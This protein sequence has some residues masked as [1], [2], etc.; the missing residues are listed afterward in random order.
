MDRLE[1]GELYCQG[2]AL[3]DAAA[4]LAR[5][6]ASLRKTRWTATRTDDARA[7]S[8]ETGCSDPSAPPFVR[9]AA[10]SAHLSTRRAGWETAAWRVLA[11]DAAAV[12]GF[13][14]AEAAAV[15]TESRVVETAA[16]RLRLRLQLQLQ[17]QRDGGITAAEVERWW[18]A[19]DQLAARA[20]ATSELLAHNVEAIEYL[21]CRWTEAFHRGG[22]GVLDDVARD[23]ESSDSSDGGGYRPS[24][25]SVTPSTS[26]SSIEEPVATRATPLRTPLGRAMSTLDSLTAL[27]VQFEAVVLSLSAAF[28]ALRALRFGHDGDEACTTEWEPPSSFERKTTKYWVEPKDVVRLKLAIVRHLPVLVFEGAG[29]KAKKAVTVNG[30]QPGRDSGMITSVYLDNAHLDVYHSRL[31]REQGATLVRTRWYGDD[32]DVRGVHGLEARREA[33]DNSIQGDVFVERKTHH[34]S[35]SL[36]GSV[37]E[38][39]RLDRCE[40]AGYLSGRLDIPSILRG[41]GA[42]EAE[43]AATLA[44]EVVMLELRN[45][46]LEPSV[47]TEYRRTAFQLSSSNTVRMSLDTRLRFTRE[48]GSTRAATHAFP[49]AILE[50]KLQEAS[51]DW[52]E[53]V[54]ARVPVIE[55]HKFSKFLHGTV[56]TG[57]ETS[58][59]CRTV[60]RVPHWCTE[61]IFAGLKRAERRQEALKCARGLGKTSCA[62]GLHGAEACPPMEAS[63]QCNAVERVA[64]SS[65]PAPISAPVACASSKEAGM[66]LK[67]E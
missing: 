31:E 30:E 26:T 61:E 47:R 36:D 42:A 23:V 59:T 64:S 1:D 4:A 15:L 63:Q 54:M 25:S 13:V 11:E 9:H 6:F 40:L 34:E 50:V 67:I 12:A 39:F 52:I 27:D 65:H 38:R 33:D 57:A 53:E 29:G 32:P 62:V 8:S 51:P 3:D 45:R 35:W 21:L 7:A 17:V 10:V 24:L 14:R 55:V 28:A 43:K 37:K 56:V 2:G 44:E 20:E 46:S 58:T 22:S 41:T 16:R 18:R 48:D 60:R 19:A 66:V 5:R 49:Y